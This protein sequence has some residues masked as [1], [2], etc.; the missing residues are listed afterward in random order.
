M[1]GHVGEVGTGAGERNEA[2]A[3]LFEIVFGGCDKHAFRGA[4]QGD[5]LA[6]ETKLLG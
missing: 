1:A 4:T 6:R 2:A 5:G 3:A